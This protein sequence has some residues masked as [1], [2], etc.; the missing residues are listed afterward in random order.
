MI[1]FRKDGN[2]AKE[3]KLEEGKKEIVSPP[4][5]LNDKDPALHMMNGS[6]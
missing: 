1:W 2:P 3:L 4:P 6:E 5:R